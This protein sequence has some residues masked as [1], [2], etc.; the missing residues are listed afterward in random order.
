MV[1]VDKTGYIFIEKEWGLLVV[2][3]PGYVMLPAVMRI[4][5][6]AM[7]QRVKEI[8]KHR[9]LI[10]SEGFKHRMG[11]K[12]WL[13]LK[14]ILL[15]QAPEGLRIAFVLPNFTHT[16]ETELVVTLMNNFGIFNAFFKNREEAIAWL[17]TSE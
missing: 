12:D 9:I 7:L 15:H 10:D 6:P 14:E 8:G 5:W 4:K 11:M 3:E 1:K 13:E 2:N 16:P 17:T